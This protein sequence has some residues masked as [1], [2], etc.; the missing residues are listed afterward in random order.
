[1]NTGLVID[2]ETQ[3][4]FQEVGLNPSKLKISVVGAFDY[5]NNEYRC[6]REKE[7]PGLFRA[8][9]HAEKIIGFNIR[10]FDLPVM[11]PYYVGDLGQ[12][13]VIDLLE[14]VEKSLGHRLSLDHLAQSTLGT[15]KSGH[16]FLA[17]EYFRKGEWDKLEKY[18][19]DDVVITKNLYEF[20]LKN[21]KLLYK[22]FSGKVIDIPLSLS[23]S[24]DNAGTVSLSLP[25]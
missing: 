25:F 15:K 2:C 11:S 6:Y 21:Q 16:G 24:P 12:F 1:M 8:M 5:K 13:T 22:N 3:Y 23:G 9:E 7:L 14:M 10:K 4:T 20:A 18:C 17:I 19:L